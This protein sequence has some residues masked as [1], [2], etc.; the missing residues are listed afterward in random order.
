MSTPKAKIRLLPLGL[1]EYQKV[2][3]LQKQ[4]QQLRIKDECPDTLILCQHPRVITMG[5][6]TDANNLL[7]PEESLRDRGIPLFRVE[8]GGDITVHNPGQLVAYPILDLNLYRRDIGWYMRSLEEVLIRTLEAFSIASQRIS[9]ET[10]V[11]CCNPHG[12]AELRKR[13]IASIGVRVS[14]WRSMHGLALNVCNDTGDFDVVNPCGFDN[15][16]ITSMLQERA[17]STEES[18]SMEFFS[19]VR[20]EFLHQFAQVFNAD[21]FEDT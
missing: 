5:K 19:M 1:E 7:V 10:G 9:G 3:D 21:L 11:W 2:W 15:I 13:K 6:S 8:R 16:S 18:E 17:H 12:Q 14:R 4:L 20:K